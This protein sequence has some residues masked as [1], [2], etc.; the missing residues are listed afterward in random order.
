M[1]LLDTHVQ[2]FC[3]PFHLYCRLY[4]PNALNMKLLFLSAML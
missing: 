3:G 2:Y 4:L 1:V